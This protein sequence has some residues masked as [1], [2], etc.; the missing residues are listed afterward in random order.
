MVQRV[1]DFGCCPGLSGYLVRLGTFPLEP[2]ELDEVIVLMD[3]TVVPGEL[4]NASAAGS[5]QTTRARSPPAANPRRDASHL[6]HAAAN[7]TRVMIQGR[8][9]YF[10]VELAKLKPYVKQGG[11]W[12]IPL[13]A[14]GAER[15]ARQW[16]RRTV[17]GVT[18]RPKVSHLPNEPG[19]AK[20]YYH[21]DLGVARGAAET[22][23]DPRVNGWH[24]RREQ[25]EVT[26][27]AGCWLRS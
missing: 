9:T 7:V 27:R 4:V 10:L 15:L 6:R 3:E 21:V 25:I 13:S 19:F 23:G 17:P 12:R 18:G 2:P 24:D 8:N 20:A 5:I 14:S 1:V 22:A 16:L 11:A 26:G